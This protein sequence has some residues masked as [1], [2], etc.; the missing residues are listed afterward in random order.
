M[1]KSYASPVIR[2]AITKMQTTLLVNDQII[3]LNEFTQDYL[4]NVIMGM[5]VALG[6]DSKDVRLHIDDSGLRIR[7]ERGEVTLRKDFPRLLIESTVKG[8][9]SPLKGIFWLGRISISCKKVNEE[10]MDN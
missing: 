4:G 1:E 6:H 3:P 10:I 8:M 9:L 2:G 5:V 7:T